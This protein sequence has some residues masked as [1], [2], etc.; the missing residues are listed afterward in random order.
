MKKTTKRILSFVLSCI[1]VCSGLQ[2]V[3]AEKTS[4]LEKA[5]NLLAALNIASD[6]SDSI[7]TREQ[8]ADIYVRANNIYQEGYVSANPFDDTDDSEYA[9]SIHIM[10]DFGIISGVGNN[11]FAPSDNILTQDIV[12]LYVSALGLDVYAESMGKGYM[13]VAYDIDLLKGVVVSDYITMDSLIMLTYNFLLAPVGVQNFTAQ[14]SYRINND[15]NMLYEKFNVYQITGQIIQNDI[16]GLFSSVSAPEG[17]VVIK[18]K[19][20]D[21]T[22]FV[23]KSGVNSM[24]G[25]T[26]DIYVYD[27]QGEYEVVCYEK[28]SNERSVTIDI[29]RINFD[30]TDNRRI[31][32]VKEGRTSISSEYLS[33][34]PAFIVNGVYY[35]IGQFDIGMLKNYT[36]KIT[37]VS[38]EKSDYDIVIVEAYANYFVENVEH[39]DGKMHIYD[40][41][42][43]EALVLD[44]T[45]YKRM[46]IYHSNG[47]KASPFEIQSG[48]LLTVA[49]SFGTQTYVKVFIS[50][51]VQEGIISR[52]DQDDRLLTMDDG[53]KYKV[54]PS[55]DL[56]HVSINTTATLYID[57]F[58]LVAWIDYDRT[59]TYTFAYL[60]S[61]PI[62]NGDD[63]VQLRAVVE[64]G[65]FTKMYLADK[66]TIDGIR[67]KTPE[68]QLLEL[69]RIPTELGNEENFKYIVTGE[70]PFRFRLNEAG[71]IKEIDSPRVSDHEDE[72]SF[73]PVAYGDG[74]ICSNDK[75]LA[76]RIPL[77][78]NTVVFAI[79]KEKYD[80][81]RDN[82]ERNH[83]EFYKV[84]NNSLMDTSNGNTY[85][86]FKIGDNSFYVDL[87][88]KLETSIGTSVGRDGQLFLVKDIM[89]VYDENSDDIR[90]KIIGL[91]A[92]TEKEYIVHK[93]FDQVELNGIKRGD[94]LRLSMNFG[95]VTV[96]EKVFIYNDANEIK[97][98]ISGKYRQPG[99]SSGLRDY[100]NGIYS[101]YYYCGY[102]TRREG[103]LIEILSFE[104]GAEDIP[105]K[106]NWADKTR[107]IF[108][109]PSKISVYDPSLG[110]KDSIYVG[111]L[112]DIPAYENGGNYAK[113]IVRC[114]NR[115]VQEMVVLK[116]QS[117]FK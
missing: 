25:H 12:K 110:K 22:A 41:G 71:E 14:Q 80:G 96:L 5:K 36:G 56:T 44:E 17:Y 97:E 18:T 75:I 109:A 106:P 7:V 83:A 111:D 100:G 49:K 104:A 77:S 78:G 101:S 52:Y 37:L 92:G 27:V 74:V 43:K 8:F 29:E 23:G 28:R 15:T 61:A 45:A 79:P 117:L 32:Y 85:V 9:D 63:K 20:A 42:I 39:H 89:T 58:G 19:D 55:Y 30:N 11:C 51:T 87:V 116:D 70:Y 1:L 93:L 68:R 6:D 47:A 54:S 3:T 102:V 34:F 48:M 108:T 69:E 67:C 53:E 72:D 90:T 38:Y 2:S 113:V 62:I 40:S 115:S 31:S 86:A 112:E 16:S 65:K 64:S 91:E 13:N 105:N 98:G 66:V 114:R 103:S 94:V 60:V 21:I 24:L 33:D 10:R 35:D 46:E 26:L 59:A 84:G 107:E 82:E 57:A 4:N 76:K 50:D 99:S 81:G 73:R 88:I 95:E